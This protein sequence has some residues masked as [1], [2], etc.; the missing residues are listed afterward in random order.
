MLRRNISLCAAFALA[1]AFTTAVLAEEPRPV[2]DAGQ[3]YYRAKQVLGAKV[4]LAPNAA[5]GVVD[6][7]V[8]DNNGNVDYL[9]VLNGEKKL[10]TVP[11]DA[12][13]FNVE[14]QMATINIAPEKFREVPTYTV[15]KYPVFSTPAYR[16]QVYRYYGLT[17]GQERRTVRRAVL[18]R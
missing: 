2:Q 8:L 4:S 9:I 17:P 13:N 1:T 7:I 12:V 6:D 5:I 16:T 10:V 14:R 18:P 11:W 3:H 15:E